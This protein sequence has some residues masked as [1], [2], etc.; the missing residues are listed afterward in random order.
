MMVMVRLNAQ[1]SYQVPRTVEVEPDVEEEDEDFLGCVGTG[2]FVWVGIGV[3]I[4]KASAVAVFANILSMVAG[5][6]AQ[7][8]REST[9]IETSNKIHLSFIVL[10]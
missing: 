2:V 8:I 6:G 7:L 3:P 10:S 4:G 5:E 9:S 1:V